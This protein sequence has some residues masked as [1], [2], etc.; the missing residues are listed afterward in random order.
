[1]RSL[2]L[3]SLL[4]DKYA[5]ATFHDAEMEWINIGLNT[6]SITFGFMIPCGFLP[7]NELSYQRGMLEFRD[8]VFYF[9]EPSVYRPEAN[10]KAALWIT[11][12]GSLPDDRVEASAELPDDLP[13][14]AFAHYFY[15]STTNSFIVVAAREA[16][17]HWNQE[18][19][20]Q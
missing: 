19:G 10:D 2:N 9:I 3:D 12:E 7:E 8:V 4:G 6:N 14:D 15:S 5:H 11:S 16:A 20:S 1:M 13:Q 18:S 17:F